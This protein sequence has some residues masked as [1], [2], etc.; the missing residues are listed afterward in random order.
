M[1]D[2]E[3]GDIYLPNGFVITPALTLSEFRQS[4]FGRGA[5]SRSLS[6]QGSWLRLDAGTIETFP[7]EVSLHFEGQRLTRVFLNAD[8]SRTTKDAHLFLVNTK[9]FHDAL[10]RSDLGEPDTFTGT[11]D[12][13]TPGL[14]KAPNHLR[15]WGKAVS[16]FDDGGGD[17]YILVEY[18]A[19][20][21]QDGRDGSD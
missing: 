16:E 20:Q 4:E 13:D 7:L 8:L 14:D 6:P 3:T 18:D 12:E 2:A 11:S 1:I 15:P 10:L 21:E 17:A 19:R 5:K 9:A